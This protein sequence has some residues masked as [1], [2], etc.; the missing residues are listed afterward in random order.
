VVRLVRTAD[1]DADVVGLLLGE[2][3]QLHAEKL[4]LREKQLLRADPT[5]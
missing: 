4:T 5:R 1:R 2:L 3:R